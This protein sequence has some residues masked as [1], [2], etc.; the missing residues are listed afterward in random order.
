[1]QVFSIFCDIFAGR[2]LQNDFWKFHR[3]HGIISTLQGERL[4]A[5]IVNAFVES[6]VMPNDLVPDIMHDSAVVCFIIVINYLPRN[7]DPRFF[8]VP[9]VVSKRGSIMTFTI[10]KVTPIAGNNKLSGQRRNIMKRKKVSLPNLRKIN[11]IMRKSG[12]N[13]NG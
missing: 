12:N 2:S 4:C 7:V 3:Q 5:K 13:A 10:C 9:H 1:M 6:L 11:D 8:V